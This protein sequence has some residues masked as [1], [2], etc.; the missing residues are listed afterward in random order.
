MIT[1]IISTSASFILFTFE[2]MIYLFSID[3][4]HH[5]YANAEVYPWCK[6]SYLF[7][8][9][10]FD[11]LAFCT[12]LIFKIA[13]NEDSTGQER[14]TLYLSWPLLRKHVANY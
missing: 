3:T 7:A 8:I 2:E 5:P 1:T 4:L 11:M 9:T 13:Y 12:I 14:I 10:C 6:S